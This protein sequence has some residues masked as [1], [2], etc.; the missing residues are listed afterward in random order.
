[1]LTQPSTRR[2]Q[3]Y[4]LLVYLH[5]PIFPQNNWRLA[6]LPN[7]HLSFPPWNIVDALP[8]SRSPPSLP[9]TSFHPS[10]ALWNAMSSRKPF[11]APELAMN[12]SPLSPEHILAES[13]NALTHCAPHFT[14]CFLMYH[15]LKHCNFPR[16][17]KSVV[18]GKYLPKW[19][20]FE[21]HLP[22]SG[23]IGGGHSATQLI[24]L[25]QIT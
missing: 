17:C 19:T 18:S 10:K 2:P 15:S 4:N 14:L 24:E 23:S 7:K 25:I 1:M 22:S 16:I 21:E 11:L 5:R 13:L 9:F 3:D 8:S 6:L 12:S 20:G